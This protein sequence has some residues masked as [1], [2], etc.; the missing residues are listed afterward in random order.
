MP[1]GGLLRRE[2]LGQRCV[3]GGALHPH[4]QPDV[5]LVPGRLCR[6]GTGLSA[7][8]PADSGTACLG[9]AAPEVCMPRCVVGSVERG[10]TGLSTIE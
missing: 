4:R 3:A 10:G 2:V 1:A 5:L 6:S 7:R 8:L 9:S